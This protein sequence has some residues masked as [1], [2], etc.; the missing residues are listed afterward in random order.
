MTTSHKRPN[1]AKNRLI[2]GIDTEYVDG[3]CMFEVSPTS[4]IRPTVRCNKRQYCF[5]GLRCDYG[6]T[7]DEL[8]QFGMD[9]NKSGTVATK[10]RKCTYGSKCVYATR[11]SRCAFAHPGEGY[12]CT[13]CST[14]NGHGWWQCPRRNAKW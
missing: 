2:R 13:I 10:Q 12:F 7:M 5:E 1:S 6:H 9:V 3:R 14:Y 11:R 4:H 8:L